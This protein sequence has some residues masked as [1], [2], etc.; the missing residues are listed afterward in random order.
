MSRALHWTASKP[1]RPSSAGTAKA[2]SYITRYL[3]R[4]VLLSGYPHNAPAFLGRRLH[5]FGRPARAIGRRSIRGVSVLPALFRAIP[6]HF[7]PGRRQGCLSLTGLR[8]TN[9]AQA[10]VKAPA[11]HPETKRNG[12]YSSIPTRQPSRPRRSAQYYERPPPAHCRSKY[13][14]PAANVL[15]AASPQG[16]ACRQPCCT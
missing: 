6:I 10:P 11:K 2:H 4:L 16:T 1:P 12:R 13:I 3:G 5:I 15:A 9:C 14:F 7:F 8:M